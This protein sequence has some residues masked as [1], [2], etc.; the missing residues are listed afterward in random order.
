M[1]IRTRVNNRNNTPS[2]KPKMTQNARY[3]SVWSEIVY[4]RHWNN[5]FNG[6]FRKTQTIGNNIET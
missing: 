2:Q 4:L 6:I 1:F 5:D 3:Y